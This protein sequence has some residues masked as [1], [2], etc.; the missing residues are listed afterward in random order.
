[1]VFYKSKFILKRR[2][3][4]LRTINFTNDLT[5]GPKEMSY[6]KSDK[7]VCLN[8]NEFNFNDEII[9]GTQPV[10]IAFWADWSGPCHI[11]APAVE[12]I[13]CEYNGKIKMG[14]LDIDDNKEIADKYSVLILPTLL[15]FKENNLHDRVT[16]VISKEELERR[17]TALL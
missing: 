12:E 5:A 6:N 9:S 11:I 17:V 14:I 8:I 16:G 15:F 2:N 1:M 13:A 3:Y 4:Y 10:V 7:S